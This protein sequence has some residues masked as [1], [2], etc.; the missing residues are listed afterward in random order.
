MFK[1]NLFFTITNRDK[2]SEENK[3]LSDLCNEDLSL[4]KVI[5]FYII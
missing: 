4:N 5:L 1:H 2:A 3:R